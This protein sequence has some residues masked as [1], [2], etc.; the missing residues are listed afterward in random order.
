M[1]YDVT[2]NSLYV[3]TTSITI[4]TKDFDTRKAL[5]NTPLKVKF[6]NGKQY[7]LK[8]DKNAQVTFKPDIPV[9]KNYMNI[10]FDENSTYYGRD[11]KINLTVNKRVSNLTVRMSGDVFSLRLNASLKDLVLNAPIKNAPVKILSDGKIITAKTSNNGF[12]SQPLSLKEGNHTLK[13]TYDGTV[14]ITNITRTVN[15]N[16]PKAKVPVTYNVTVLNNIYGNDS[17]RVTLID[18]NTSKAI[19]YQPVTIKL[20]QKSIKLQTDNQGHVTFRSNM[21]PGTNNMSMTYAGNSKYANNT[22]KVPIII[23][24]RPSFMN[25]SLSYGYAMLLELT[26]RDSINAS[27]IPNA[28]IQVKHPKKTITLKTDKNG[29]VSSRLDLPEG[30]ARITV[31]FPGDTYYLSSNSTSNEINFPKIIKNAK[32][33]MS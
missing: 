3:D 8:T 26:L 33:S 4:K 14:N 21:T 29:K 15:V 28:T 20:P 12:F 1:D 22:A 27:V 9:G 24:K 23:L 10:L 18:L 11:E 31:V 25:V 5:P 17:I 13:V 6:S 16:V 32:K 2:L 30:K 19:A 7:S